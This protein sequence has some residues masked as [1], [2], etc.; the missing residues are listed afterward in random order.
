M[1]FAATVIENRS[2]KKAERL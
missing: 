1:N 2:V